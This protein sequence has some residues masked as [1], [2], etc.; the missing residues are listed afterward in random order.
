MQVH[1]VRG[2]G[3]RRVALRRGLAVGRRKRSAALEELRSLGWWQGQRLGEE[4]VE[5]RRL[6]Y[7][8][9]LDVRLMED[10][11]VKWI[12]RVGKME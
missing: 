6:L 12:D 10:T 9:T 4:R 2:L 7:R 8:A 1:V 5:L 11:R 3:R